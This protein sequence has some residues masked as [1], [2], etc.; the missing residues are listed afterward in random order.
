[1]KL[2]NRVRLLVT[3]WTAAYQA[4]PSM[5]FSRQ[6]YWS[7][8]PLPSFQMLKTPYLSLINYDNNN[9]QHHHKHLVLT[10]QERKFAACSLHYFN[11]ALKSILL[12]C[13]EESLYIVWSPGPNKYASKRVGRHRTTAL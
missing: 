11:L 2:L 8:V 12:L 1:M 13:L 5:G 3:P 9:T 7:G 6:E 10:S 4:P